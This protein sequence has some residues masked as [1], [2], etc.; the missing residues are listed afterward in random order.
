MLVQ[1]Q[2]GN[3]TYD[4]T[5]FKKIMICDDLAELRA[6][7][8]VGEA[9]LFSIRVFFMLDGNEKEGY[10]LGRYGD[11]PAAIQAYELLLNAIVSG[12]TFF[13]MVP[14]RDREIGELEQ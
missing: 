3:I 1:E 13:S 14:Q 7:D 9:A 6:L 11:Y 5:G 12:A 8:M 4:I 2:S 10:I